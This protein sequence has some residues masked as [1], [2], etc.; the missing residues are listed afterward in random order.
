MDHQPPQEAFPSLDRSD[1]L[2]STLSPGFVP[3]TDPLKIVPSSVIHAACKGR[4]RSPP[5]E[6]FH[7]TIR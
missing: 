6:R 3:A 7:P 4:V 2:V 1:G 5:P